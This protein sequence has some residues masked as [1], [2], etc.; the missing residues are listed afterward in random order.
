MMT[1]FFA[2][3]SLKNVLALSNNTIKLGN[4]RFCMNFYSIF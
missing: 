4:H 1:L 2:K 3:I